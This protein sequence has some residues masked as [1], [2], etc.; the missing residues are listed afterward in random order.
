MVGP[1]GTLRVSQIGFIVRD[2]ETTKEKLAAFLGIPVPPTVGGGDFAITQTTVNGQPAPDANCQM[3]FFDLENIQ[4]ELIQPNGVKSTWQDFLD[5]RG[6]GIHHIAFGV[7]GTDERSLPAKPWASPAPSGANTAT[8]A[9]NMPISMPPRP[10]SALSRPW[11]AINERGFSSM[12]TKPV[13]T[14]VVGCGIISQVYLR[15]MTRL[16]SILDVVAVCDLVPELAQEAAR[17]Y[18]IPLVVDM[19]VPPGGRG[20]SGMKMMDNPLWASFFVDCWE[21]IVRKTKGEDGIYAY[22]L[23]NEPT[24]FGAPK[25][26]DYLEIQRRAACAVRAIDPVTPVIVSCMNDVAWCAPSAFKTMAPVDMTN[27]FY[28]FHMYEPFEYT[29][30]KVLPQFK[31]VVA[32]YPDDAK[33]WNAAGLRRII[34][35]VLAFERRF[36]AHIFVGEFSAIAYAEGCGQWIADV[37]EMLNECRW[38]WCYHA[39]REW[40]GWS[41]EHVVTKGDSASNAKFAPSADNARKR[42]LVAGLRGVKP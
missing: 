35:P 19:H 41:V 22:D 20:G 1:L 21:K 18:G 31:D 10:S 37:V 29:H 36:G 14:A 27:I 17:K 33:G 40:P 42:A 26:C 8:A 39:F 25:H 16:F 13:K 4:L 2:I 12:Q 7:K 3:A 32:A 30:Q 11:K 38:D 5:T 24:Q 34:E 28:Q 15:N 23:I 9:A 6:E